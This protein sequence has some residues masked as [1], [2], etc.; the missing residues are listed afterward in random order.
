MTRQS[1]PLSKLARHARVF[2]ITFGL[3]AGGATAVKAADSTGNIDTTWG[4][5]GL[6][7]A[8]VFSPTSAYGSK[9]VALAGDKTLHLVRLTSGFSDTGFGLVQVTSTGALDTTFSTDGWLK[10]GLTAGATTVEGITP[11][12]LTV[13][14]DNSILVTGGFYDNVNTKA[15]VFAAKY[16]SAGAP[17]A[18]FGT[19]GISFADYTT[20][21]TNGSNWLRNTPI[22]SVSASGKI[23]AYFTPNGEYV[24]RLTADGARDTTFATGDVYTGL[25]F[26]T[27]LWVNANVYVK[28]FT[29]D[30]TASPVTATFFG[31][32]GGSGSPDKSSAVMYRMKFG[33]TIRVNSSGMDIDTG[34]SGITYFG[35]NQGTTTPG[36]SRTELPVSGLS[37]PSA[38]ALSSSG[39]AYMTVSNYL[40]ALDVSQRTPYRSFGTNGIATLTSTGITSVGALKVASVGPDKILVGGSDANYKM[41]VAKFDQTNGQLVSGF[42]SGGVATLTA[43]SSFHTLGDL[44]VTT[45]GAVILAGSSSTTIN[46]SFVPAPQLARLGSGA[47]TTQCGTTTTTTTQAPQ[48]NGGG[49]GGGLPTL[50]NVTAIE[51]AGPSIKVDVSGLSVGSRLN[52]MVFDRTFMPVGNSAPLP[53]GWLGDVGVSSLTVTGVRFIDRQGNLVRVDPFEAGKTYDLMIS[54]IANNGGG[55]VTNKSVVITGS[56]IA[57]ATA[58]STT[59]ASTT[60]VVSTTTVAPAAT[61]TTT[62]PKTVAVAVKPGVSVTDTK[63]YV[64]AP[65]AKVSAESAI[66]V[67]TPAQAKV[68]EIVS[69]TPAVCVPNNDEIVFIDTG[70]CVAKIMN[71]KTGALLRTVRTNVVEDEVSTLKVGNE[72]AILAPIYF[73]GGSSDVNA[74]GLARLKAIK[75]QVSAAGSVLLV[76]HSGVL[77]GDIPANRALAKARAVSTA[78]LL[79]KIGATGPFYATSAS[80]FDPVSKAQT[81]RGQNK[82][83]RVV[84]ILVP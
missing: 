60:T 9:S 15:G 6:F 77:M 48:N 5:G 42:G 75:A 68:Q 28:A 65:P 73:D 31:V 7:D 62:V 79:K 25:Y 37:R 27:P 47:V 34:Y 26:G 14:S 38:V 78:K 49:G 76:G 82:N 8:S 36:Y 84:I 63:V 57:P 41:V 52:V 66:T 54:Q 58:T 10:Q 39:F 40:V 32:D 72:I 43:C 1:S 13:L 51:I 17:F 12:N 23:Y 70:K 2:V 29:V 33:A 4:E 18:G 30:E 45:S 81:Q 19:N 61:T 35:A 50:T 46:G 64:A 80:A 71:E 83:R 53:S 56:V 69:M 24:V 22:T 55:G 11:T 21:G 44:V 74:K 16:D 20:N 3:I 59:I 67:M